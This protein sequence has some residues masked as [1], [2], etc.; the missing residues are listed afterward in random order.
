MDGMKNVKTN[1]KLHFM[2]LLYLQMLILIITTVII[3]IISIIISSA[4]HWLSGT[5]FLKQK[6]K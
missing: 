6:N 3:S 1:N 5:M 2:F 4:L